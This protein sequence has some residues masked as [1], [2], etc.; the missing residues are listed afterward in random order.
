MAAL[1][2]PEGQCGRRN[3]KDQRAG[4][5]AQGD[6][7][8]DG[9]HGGC[10]LGVDKDEDGSVDRARLTAKYVLGNFESQHRQD[11]RRHNG[12]ATSL[13]QH[14]PA[15]LSPVHVRTEHG[16]E[17]EHDEAHVHHVFNELEDHGC[18]AERR[19][20][21]IVTGSS[22]RIAR[23]DARLPRG[24]D[25]QHLVRI[26]ATW[27]IHAGCRRRQCQWRRHFARG[28]PGKWSAPVSN[29]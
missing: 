17:A 18:I 20:A 10:D 3:H 27:H 25:Q 19:Q 29:R 22:L 24:I 13:Q 26:L 7:L 12:Q 2:P 15:W 16:I 8:E 21:F 1:D 9:R 4:R 6:A 14:R 28:R 5:S 23:K 11:E